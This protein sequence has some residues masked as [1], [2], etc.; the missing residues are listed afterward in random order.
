MSME[1]AI[2]GYKVICGIWSLPFLQ[3]MCIIGLLCSNVIVN[4][5]LCISKHV[6]NDSQPQRQLS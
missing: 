4:T 3:I 5:A 1:R 6:S 2:P